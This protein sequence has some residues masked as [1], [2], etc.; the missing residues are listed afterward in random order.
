[1]MMADENF[2]AADELHIPRLRLADGHQPVL[3]LV[4]LVDPQQRGMAFINGYE[5]MLNHTAKMQSGWLMISA[6]VAGS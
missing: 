3:G 2:A 5:F 4:P 6:K 1:M